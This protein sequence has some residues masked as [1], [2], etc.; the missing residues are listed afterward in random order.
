MCRPERVCSCVHVACSC[1]PRVATPS[2]F[3]NRWRAPGGRRWGWPGG[4]RA[5]GGENQPSQPGPALTRLRVLRC[6]SVVLS[7]PVLSCI[8]SGRVLSCLMA[9]LVPVLSLSYLF[10]L[11][12]LLICPARC[13]PLSCPLLCLLS[14]VFSAFWLVLSFP[15]WSCPLS[16]VPVPCVVPCPV[17]LGISV[18][19]PLL[20]WSLS[21]PGQLGLAQPL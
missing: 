4:R 2:R 15:V 20:L 10:C 19:L 12:C 8:L 14:S 13:R 18:A 3:G 11:S 6:C 5:A 1:P 17:R 21:C 9:C 7:C 16:S